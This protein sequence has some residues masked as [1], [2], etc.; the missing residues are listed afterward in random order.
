MQ[1]KQGR[2]R[3]ND[4]SKSIRTRIIIVCC[5]HTAPS[6]EQSSSIVQLTDLRLHA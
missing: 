2:M 4:A 3:N 6:A 5:C 1:A